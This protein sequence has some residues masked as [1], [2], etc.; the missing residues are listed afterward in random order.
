MAGWLRPIFCPMTTR[1]IAALSILGLSC[2][3]GPSDRG[4]EE[5]APP[6]RE[7]LPADAGLPEAGGVWS[8][9][10]DDGV[11]F[12]IVLFENGQAVATR[13]GGTSGARGERG[14]WRAMEDCV[15]VFFDD[16]HSARFV[17]RDG[18]VVHEGFAP[19]MGVSSRAVSFTSP[20]GR[21]GGPR[22]PFVGIWRLNREPDGSYLYV[23][24]R[25][26]GS[27]FS[28]V[29][30]LTEGQWDSDGE[31][32]L[33]NWPDGWVDRIERAAGSWHKKSWVGAA[34]GTPADLSEAAR[35]GETRFLVSP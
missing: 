15:A 3:C 25:S 31:A 22:A 21:I 8:V 9:S 34:E 30:G 11:P 6:P 32:A 18:A 33:C 13:V 2:G 17:I 28:T 24:L 4:V 10:G 14:L 20:A 26:D 7:P 35:V 23:T 19:G 29:N 5:D 27:A 16:G 1:W 12:D